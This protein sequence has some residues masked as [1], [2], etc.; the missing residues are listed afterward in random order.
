M[1][2]K[3]NQTRLELSNCGE[4]AAALGQE[5]SEAARLMRMS[6]AWLAIRAV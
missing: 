4:V 3:F 2:T 1:Q 6:R 5:P